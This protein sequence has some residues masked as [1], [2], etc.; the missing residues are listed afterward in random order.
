M[1]LEK[2]KNRSF[3]LLE[4]Q[5]ILSRIKGIEFVEYFTLIREFQ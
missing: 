4:S 3:D 5:L 1:I 2:L